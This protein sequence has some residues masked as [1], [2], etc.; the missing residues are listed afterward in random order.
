[1]SSFLCS[2]ETLS[3]VAEK[4]AERADKLGKAHGGDIDFWFKKI[5]KMN[6]IASNALNEQDDARE[7]IKQCGKRLIRPVDIVI[8]CRCYEYQTAG[9]YTARA[10]KKTAIH[11]LDFENNKTMRTI[12]TI[13]YD[14]AMSALRS[15]APHEC[16]RAN[17][18]WWI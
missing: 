12:R 10:N 17:K 2:S 13:G 16:M 8:A 1:M 18:E 6:R 5:L 11:T 4:L 9:Y 14:A 3:L 7:Y 15:A